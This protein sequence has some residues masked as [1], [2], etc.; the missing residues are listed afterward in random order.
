MN[1]QPRKF[2]SEWLKLDAERNERVR[3]AR[4][5]RDAEKPPGRNIEE[6]IALIEYFQEFAAA[7]RPQTGGGR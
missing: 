6:S 1:E 2:D 4:S 3:R 7:F 5:R